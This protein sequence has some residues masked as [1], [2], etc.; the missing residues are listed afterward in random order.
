MFHELED[1]NLILCIYKDLYHI[2]VLVM[3]AIVYFSLALKSLINDLFYK[4][5]IIQK[6]E[7]TFT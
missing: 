2:T 1:Y 7:R 6:V 5:Q 4:D 3:R